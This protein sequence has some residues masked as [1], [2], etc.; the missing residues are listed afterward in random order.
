MRRVARAAVVV[1]PAGSLSFN[2]FFCR[3]RRAPG[4]LVVS[5][6]EERETPLWT[7]MPWIRHANYALDASGGDRFAAAAEDAARADMV[8]AAT[9]DKS[10]VRAATMN[11]SRAVAFFDDLMAWR[12]AGLVSSY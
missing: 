8:S 11:V 12:G 2:A 4:C 9:A 1:T 5:V 3:K 7:A 10:G 6:G